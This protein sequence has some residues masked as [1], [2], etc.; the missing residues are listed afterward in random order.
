MSKKVL[1]ISLSALLVI[2]SLFLGGFILAYQA[3]AD[4]DNDDEMAEEEELNDEEDE[5]LEDEDVEDEEDLEHEAA[6][7]LI[8]QV[9]QNENEISRLNSMIS[10]FVSASL[11]WGVR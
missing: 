9:R 4:T 1:A 3:D 8:R 6:E 5:E 10:P 2:S 11:S 7:F